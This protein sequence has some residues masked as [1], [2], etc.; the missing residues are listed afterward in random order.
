[1]LFGVCPPFLPLLFLK[2]VCVPVPVCLPE[3][4]EAGSSFLFASVLPPSALSCASRAALSC[5]SRTSFL[6]FSQESSAAG[7]VFSLWT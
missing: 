7:S 4:E 2:D 3:V 6:A 1:M 5:L